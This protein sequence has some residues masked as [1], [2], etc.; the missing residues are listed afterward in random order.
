MTTSEPP[1]IDNIVLDIAPEEASG[2]AQP[3]K[4]SAHSPGET[5]PSDSQVEEEKE[6]EWQGFE[7]NARDW[8]SGWTKDEEEGG[9]DSPLSSPSSSSRT[10]S[11]SV[12]SKVLDSPSVSMRSPTITKPKGMQLLKPHSQNHSSQ[13][14][15]VPELTQSTTTAV[16]NS[17]KLSKED[18]ARLEEQFHWAAIEPDLFADMAPIIIDASKL[19]LPLP[20]PGENGHEPERKSHKSL[21]PSLDYQP[22]EGEVGTIH[23]HNNCNFNIAFPI[24]GW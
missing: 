20:P 24:T 9:K 6:N 16:S 14:H 19:S 23:S 4:E 5:S 21:V 12:S 17:Y 1:V 11:S 8:G 15:S 10:V 7:A 22:Q 2:E 13:S 3:E 18:T